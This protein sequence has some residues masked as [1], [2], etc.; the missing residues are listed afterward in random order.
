M[1]FAVLTTTAR[2]MATFGRSCR[3]EGGLSLEVLTKRVA[4]IGLFAVVRAGSVDCQPSGQVASGV[5]HHSASL[6]A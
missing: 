1:T 4:T 5:P 6:A 3:R 2:S